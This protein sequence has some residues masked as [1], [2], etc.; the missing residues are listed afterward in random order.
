[1]AEK[2]SMYG[3]QSDDEDVKIAPQEQA[4]P[5]PLPKTKLPDV[6]HVRSSILD[7]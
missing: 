3:E 1:M 7:Y 5:A 6:S 2:K 4:K